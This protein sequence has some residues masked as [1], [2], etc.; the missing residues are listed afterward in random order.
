MN[1]LDR[2]FLKMVRVSPV[3]RVF[4]KL[5]SSSRNLKLVINM[6]KEKD[7]V[8]D[9]GCGLGFTGEYLSRKGFTVTGVEL[10]S[11]L[12][13]RVKKYA[14]YDLDNQNAAELPYQD[15]SF[16]SC[17]MMYVMHHIPTEHHKQ[18]LSEIS[19]I[20]KKNGKLIMIEPEPGSKF[21][22]AWDKLFFRDNF[23]GYFELGGNYNLVKKGNI[24]IF[25]I[26][27]KDIPELELTY[28]GEIE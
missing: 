13:K 26:Q 23:Y 22:L 18:V 12:V 14:S 4:I 27:N 7:K 1:V 5:H 19:R 20:L 15:G 3:R 10:D 8:L 2:V 16:D 17:I 6:L 25:E 11:G 28:V 9:V 21:D 24:R